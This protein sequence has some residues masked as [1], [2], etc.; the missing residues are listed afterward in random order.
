MA[1]TNRNQAKTEANG[2]KADGNEQTQQQNPVFAIQRI[3]N[4]DISFESPSAPAIF[5]EQW[6]PNVHLDLGVKSDR[7][8][9]HA[10]EVVLTLTV[11]VKNG[12]KS[13]FLIEVQ[14]A[15]IFT[16][17]GFSNEQMQRMLGSYCPNVLFPYAREVISDL[18]VRGGFPP[19]YLAPINFDA[20][21][22]QTLHQQK[23]DQKA[24]QKEGE[25]NKA[26]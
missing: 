9:E 14:Q 1:T 6:H 3:Y 13:S 18:V 17:Q 5:R 26:N 12:E 19:L 16:L 20:V 25:D 7:L 11:T 23:Q 24:E 22:E 21:F 10:H 8:E 4:K 2:A 15:G